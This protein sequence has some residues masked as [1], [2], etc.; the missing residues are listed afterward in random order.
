MNYAA[1]NRIYQSVLL[2]LP[3]IVA[4]AFALYSLA[5]F[6]YSFQTWQRMKRDTDAFIVADSERRA[7]VLADYVTELRNEAGVH[8]ELFEIRAYLLNRDLGMS[9]R[10][11][12][13]ASLQAIEERFR[14][15]AADRWSST[16]SRIVF[17]DL[18]GHALADTEPQKP[19]PPMPP[20]GTNTGGIQIDAEHSQFLAFAPVVHRGSNAGWVITQSTTEVMY[21]HL[22]GPSAGDTY[23]ELL[24]TT[25]GQALGGGGTLSARQ[26]SAIASVTN[27][28]VKSTAEMDGFK[29]QRNKPETL[30]VKSPVQG[31]ALS[32]V[33]LIGPERAYG[34][35]AS[36]GFLAGAA[37]VP[38]LL[39]A[40]AIW[41][42]RMRASAARLQTEVIVAEHQRHAVEQRNVEMTAEMRRREVIEAALLER[43]EQLNAIFALSPDGFVSFDRNGIVQHVSP[44]FERMTGLRATEVFGLDENVFAARVNAISEPTK[45]LPD[46]KAL[47]DERDGGDDSKPKGE[48]RHFIEIKTTPPRILEVGR[49]RSLDQSVSQ[50]IWFR[51]VTIESEVSRL[52]SEFLSTAAHELRTPMASILGYSELMLTDSFDA[53]QQRE[54][55][56]CIHRNSEV[57]ATI[58]NELLDLARIEAR[59]GKDFQFETLQADALL[60]DIMGQ[61]V[62]PR[63]RAPPLLSTSGVSCGLRGDRSK[64]AQSIGNVLSN[65]YKYSPAGGAVEVD[66]IVRSDALGRPRA[67]VRVRD[68]GIG[69]T[70]EQL[71]HVTERFYRADSSGKIPGTGLGM[72]IVR[73]I[74]ELHGGELELSST[75]GAGTTVTLWLPCIE[76]RGNS[77]P[78]VNVHRPGSTQE[79]TA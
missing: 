20:A 23:Q 29:D 18:A 42:D 22:I 64:L 35:L 61:F 31:I 30:L 8:A 76:L 43:T 77:I 9:P 2:R 40:G 14:L 79:L 78:T 53:G 32:L 67:G 15:H 60:R 59:R 16:P 73:E 19:L 17:I 54:F 45:H 39:L 49:R 57:I 24:V 71:S 12:L 52:K 48:Q 11:G 70:P 4:V 26:A 28:H 63:T 38:L 51:D 37:I 25:G 10:Y 41:L 7:A 58:I 1:P 6:A 69:M 5:L 44:A 27:G 21:R 65:A 74:T 75:Q 50:I 56:E 3:V 33:T 66:L 46:T 68:H 72:S 34:H 47:Y 62:A 36:K 13:D 55:I